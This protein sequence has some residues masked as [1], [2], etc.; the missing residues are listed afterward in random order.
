VQVSYDYVANQPDRLSKVTHV[1]IPATLSSYQY[2]F[3]QNTA[4]GKAG[5]RTKLTETRQNGTQT[6][7]NW[8]Y[9]AAYRLSSERK[10]AGSNVITGFEYDKAGN[11]TRLTTN[12]ATVAT[13]EYDKLDRLLLLK[14]ATG[15]ISEEYGYDRRG[16]QSQVKVGGTVARS[17]QWD[18]ADRLLG[19]TVGSTSVTMKYDADGRRLQSKTVGSLITETNYLCTILPQPLRVDSP[20]GRANHQI[21]S[22]TYQPSKPFSQEAKAP[23]S[24]VMLLRGSTSSSKTKFLLLLMV[25][26]S[27]NAA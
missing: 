21:H 16:N 3:D 14:N 10:I 7:Y 24:Q 11:R 25:I 26:Y 2:E 4:A 1:K 15:A 5:L 17:Y 9:D 12:G 8:T 18:G 20:P 22:D 13:Y 19:A 23:N 6:T 27:R